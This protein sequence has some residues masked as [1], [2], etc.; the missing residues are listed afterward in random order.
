MLLS[1]LTADLPWASPTRDVDVRRAVVDS[2][3]VQPGDLFVAI[4]GEKFDGAKFIPQAVQAGAA[5]VAL[6]NGTDTL[7]AV[8]VSVADPRR[9][10][11]IAAHRLAGDPTASMRVIGATGTNGKT[12]VIYQ[13]EAIEKAAGRLV[14]LIGTVDYHYNSHVF[15]AR[16]TTPEAPDLVAM[17]VEMKE[18]GVQ[19][20]VMEISSHALQLGRAIGCHLDAAV[21]T[22]L[23]RDHLDF[24]GA[25]DAYLSA[26]LRLFDEILPVSARLKPDVFAAVNVD[27]PAGERV[28]Q[29]TPVRTISYG[30]SGEVRWLELVCD[31]DGLRGK[32]KY[33]D[34]VV[35]VASPLLGDFQAHNVL[36]AATVSY[37][38]G[39]APE[40]LVAGLAACTRIPGRLEP[41]GKQDFLVLVDYAHTPDA[42]DN[43]VSTLKR[44]AIGRVI[45]VFGCGG[46]RDRGKRPMMGK[47]VAQQANISLVTSDNPRSEE[48]DDIIRQILPGIEKTGRR[49]VAPRDLVGHGDNGDACY[50]VEPDRATAIDLAIQ[51]ARPGDVV[52]IAGKGHEDYQIIGDERIHF[53]DREVASEALARRGVS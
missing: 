2:R 39:T 28:L 45:V 52:L 8:K 19:T 18:F 22:N 47:A 1:K 5:A 14:G 43:V 13:L 42:L 15:H 23:S 46:D 38:L 6:E 10:A 40:A 12:S 31:F 50:A 51:I 24:H 53:D 11:A 32:L 7:G 26:K 33:G 30:N 34:R 44:L 3:Q 4:R 16:F 17:L 35:Q 41:V 49:Q 25:L 21:F 37:G 48:P 36:A 27:D 20:V 29:A 9:F